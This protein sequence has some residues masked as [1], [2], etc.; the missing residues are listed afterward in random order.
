MVYW[1]G[2]RDQLPRKSSNGAWGRAV[3]AWSQPVIFE[4]WPRHV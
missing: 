3:A 2:P 1:V 4:K